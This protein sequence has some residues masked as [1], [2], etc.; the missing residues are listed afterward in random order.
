[1][2]LNNQ[3]SSRQLMSEYSDYQVTEIEYESDKAFFAKIKNLTE[4]CVWI[5]KSVVNPERKI[6]QW[7]IDQKKKELLE[8]EK[9]KKQKTMTNYFQR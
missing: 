6:K 2:K 7:F 3:I 9:K 1:M 5:P 8:Y 4:V